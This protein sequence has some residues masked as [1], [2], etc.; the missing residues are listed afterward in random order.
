MVF[1]LQSKGKHLGISRIATGQFRNSEILQ[2]STGEK[3]KM[4]LLKSLLVKY[5]YWHEAA[6]AI[7]TNFFTDINGRIWRKTTQMYPH[8]FQIFVTVDII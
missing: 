7:S 2:A 6:C 4:E 8:I 5:V 1:V 3:V